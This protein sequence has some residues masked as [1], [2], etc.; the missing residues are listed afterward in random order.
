MKMGV[1][2]VAEGALT[3]QESTA[4]SPGSSTN[5]NDGDDNASSSVPAEP[6]KKRQ[7]R[8][9]EMIDEEVDYTIPN[10]NDPDS[11][12]WVQYQSRYHKG[13]WRPGRILRKNEHLERKADGKEGE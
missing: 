2:E 3:T 6:S 10:L 11:L 8:R 12:K 9:R 7:R 5:N 1:I 4:T 13:R